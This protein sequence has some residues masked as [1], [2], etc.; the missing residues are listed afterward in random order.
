MFEFVRADF[1]R[2]TADSKS[3]VARVGHLLLN[4]GVHAVLL[5]RLSRW[6]HLHHLAPLGVLV[7]YV[8]SVITGAYISGRATIGKGLVIHHPHGTVIGATSVIGDD[9]T[10]VHGNVIGQLHGWDDR[11]T[12][13]DR[14]TAATGAKILGRVTIG[15][16]VHV[17]ANSVVIRSLPDGVT[18]FGLPARIVFGRPRERST[19]VD[20]PLTRLAIVQRLAS[21]LRR[22]LD[23]PA[24]LDTIDESTALY[25]AGLGVDSIE[26]LKLVCAIEAEFGLTIDDVELASTHFDTVGSLT[27]FI[28]AMSKPS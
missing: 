19:A 8:N 14:F 9:C 21:L 5:Y 3:A 15:N 6:L 7:S 28:Q 10:L 4:P 13:G 17:G 24:P 23:L 27:A 26:M 12:V 22:D 11:P 20:T 2:T 1:R 18:A 25:G 16:D